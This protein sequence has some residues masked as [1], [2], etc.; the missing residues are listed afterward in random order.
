MCVESLAVKN[1]LKNHCLAKAISDVGW[2]EFLRQLEYKAKWYGRTFIEI[3]R[4][5]PTSKTCSAC[6]EVLEALTLDVREWACPSCGVYHDRDVNAACNIL[7]A[8]L[9]VNTA[10]GGDI[11]PV[12]ARVGQAIP[13]EAG[14][15]R[16]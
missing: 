11:R 15:S 5:S 4:F 7:A 2:G 14:R 10:C 1:L 16:L 13:N 12:A 6:G 3:D 8:G 9:V